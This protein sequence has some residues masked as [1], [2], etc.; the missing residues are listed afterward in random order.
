MATRCRVSLAGGRTR[1]KG[2]RAGQT[3]G[4]GKAAWGPAHLERWVWGSGCHGA[5]PAL[6]SSLL[7]VL[8][9]HLFGWFG[10]CTCPIA[11][12]NCV[13]VRAKMAVLS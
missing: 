2:N 6:L 7:T 4:L 13:C 1:D 12:P 9:G 11:Q 8:Q 3:E 10:P 5:G